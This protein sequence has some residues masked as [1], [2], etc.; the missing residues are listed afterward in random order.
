MISAGAWRKQLQHQNLP[1]PTTHRFCGQNFLD[2][3][4]FCT[5]WVGRVK[6]IG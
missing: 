1:P 6:Q 4:S 5:C 3:T 2:T